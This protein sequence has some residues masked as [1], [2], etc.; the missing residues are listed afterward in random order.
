VGGEEDQCPRRKRY[1]CRCCGAILPAWLPIAKRPDEAILLYHLSQHHPN[2]VGPY[3]E[4]MRT[5]CIA[6]V[7]AETYEVVDEY[8]TR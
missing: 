7:A 8:E 6:T 4:R 1:R 5:K 3:L 2:Q